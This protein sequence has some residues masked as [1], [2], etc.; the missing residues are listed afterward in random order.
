MIETFA[1]QRTAS[2]HG[3]DAE[4]TGAAVALVRTA[5]QGSPHADAVLPRFGVDADIARRERMIQIMA[6]LGRFV[7]I[8]A[9]YLAVA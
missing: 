6:P 3:V 8:G 1:S 9:E 4:E 5:E 7:H 2:G